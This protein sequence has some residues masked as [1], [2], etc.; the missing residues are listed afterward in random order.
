[1]QTCSP[2]RFAVSCLPTLGLHGVSVFKATHAGGK[3]VL[4]ARWLSCLCFLQTEAQ[5]CAARSAAWDDSALP[6]FY[7]CSL[8]NSTSGK[9][10]LT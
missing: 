4:P 6:A 5:L 8:V 2:P 7:L 9:F 1:M 3:W 10:F